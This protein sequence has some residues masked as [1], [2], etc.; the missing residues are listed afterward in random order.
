MAQ[1][2]QEVL[3][4]REP[5]EGGY[6]EDVVGLGDLATNPEELE[7]IIELAVDVAADGNWG[8]DRLHVGLLQEKLLHLH[9]KTTRRKDIRSSRPMHPLFHPS[10]SSNNPVTPDHD[11]SLVEEM[12]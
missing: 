11:A 5:T 2:Q 3:P 8:G 9:V 12:M 7:E 1:G 4:K 10:T 6:H